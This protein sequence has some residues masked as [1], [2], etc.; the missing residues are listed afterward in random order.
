MEKGRGEWEPRSM[1]AACTTRS[2]SSPVTPTY[3][4]VCE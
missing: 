4:R 1:E 2:I 3:V